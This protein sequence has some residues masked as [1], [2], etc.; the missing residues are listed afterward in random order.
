MRTTV[1][2]A[3]VM[4]LAVS[5][6]AVVFA[7]GATFGQSEPSPSPTPINPICDF[8]FRQALA[9]LQTTPDPVPDASGTPGP[10]LAA[11]EPTVEVSI[12]DQAIRSC[13][14]LDEFIAAA[15][16]YPEML[17]DT[18]PQVFLAGRCWD[19][20]AGLDAYAT[21]QS[22]ERAIATPSPS[23]SPSPTPGPTPKRTPRPTSKPT[24][25]PTP[26]A[27]S[28][29]RPKASASRKGTA[30]VPQGFR[31]RVA[32]A[33]RVRYF[34][35]RGKSPNA[36]MASASRRAKRFC[37]S[38]RAIACVRSSGPRLRGIVSG[39]TGRCTTTS[40]SWP[41]SATVAYMPRWTAPKRAPRHVVWWWKKVGARIGWHEAQHVRI[42]WEHRAKFPRL[43]G[44]PCAKADRKTSN[45]AK[46]LSREQKAFDR[47]DYPRGD[48][49]SQRFFI[50]ALRRFGP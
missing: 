32:G 41:S 48:A 9:D 15:S 5:L 13:A 1:T 36:L 28:A 25:K 14:S 22:F 8:A 3:R 24:P 12:L 42:Y 49:A 17:G 47:A 20:S 46:T 38:G 18:D 10:D 30:W 50:A 43:V 11:T 44:K 45:W 35:I 31:A 4:W 7:S 21:C 2:R 27:R 26:T 19:S 40:V 34:D 39:T 37:S 33:D 6:L 16:M 29:A 23:P